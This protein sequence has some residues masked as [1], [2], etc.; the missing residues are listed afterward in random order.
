MNSKCVEVL[1]V[2]PETMGNRREKKDLLILA[3]ESFFYYHTEI[4]GKKNKNK[5]VGV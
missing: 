3:S 1:N 4:S 2:S 5:H